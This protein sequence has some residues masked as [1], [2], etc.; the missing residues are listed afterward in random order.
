MRRVQT[1]SVETD[2]LVLDDPNLG[3][4][5]RGLCEVLQTDPREIVA[6]TIHPQRVMVTTRSDAPR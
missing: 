4:L 1:T 5:V 6:L 3:H 2:G